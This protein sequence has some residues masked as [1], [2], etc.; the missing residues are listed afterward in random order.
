[1]KT[2]NTSHDTKITAGLEFEIYDIQPP[3]I[4]NQKISDLGVKYQEQLKKVKKAKVLKELKLAKF[5]PEETKELEYLAKIKKGDKDF[6]GVVFDDNSVMGKLEFLSIES[7][8][9]PVNEF[10]AQENLKDIKSAIIGFGKTIKANINQ[11]DSN[12]TLEFVSKNKTKFI[13]ELFEYSKPIF[14]NFT[15]SISQGG[16]VHVT[17]T[18][19]QNINQSN[20]NLFIKNT[21]GN[22]GTRQALFQITTPTTLHTGDRTT[23][24]PNP[25]APLE[26][27]IDISENS[28]F[29]EAQKKYAQSYNSREVLYP[30]SNI[31]KHLKEDIEVYKEVRDEIVKININDLE[32]LQYAMKKLD[33]TI[34]Q[35][36]SLIKNKEGKDLIFHSFEEKLQPLIGNNFLVEHRDKTQDLTSLCE[37]Y[38]KNNRYDKNKYT[39]IMKNFSIIEPSEVMPKSINI[40]PK[41]L[42]KNNKLQKTTPE[43]IKNSNPSGNQ[44]SSFVDKVILETKGKQKPPLTT[45]S[46]TKTSYVK[47]IMIKGKK[48]PLDQKNNQ[49]QK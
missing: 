24:S 1:M 16:A 17:H 22:A 9:M 34:D 49:W 11:L 30:M 10:L 27:I 48:Y 38:L 21:K 46:V 26:F 7:G 45:S 32:D 6:L 5:F 14:K 15:T 47:T 18:C 35:L 31:V 4:E 19:P 33:N 3:L 2:V 41:N 29:S 20:D 43:P 37:A 23:N 25:K 28:Q 44:K 40:I 36:S 42:E 39:N 13:V 8:I 12:S